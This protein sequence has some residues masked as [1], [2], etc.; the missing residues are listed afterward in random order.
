MTA[1][2]LLPKA[3]KRRVAFKIWEKE[4]SIVCRRRERRRGRH[5][6]GEDWTGGKKRA[7]LKFRGKIVLKFYCNE[8]L[9]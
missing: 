4:R 8:Y 5:R 9:F 1:T 2:C 6:D 7:I 3:T